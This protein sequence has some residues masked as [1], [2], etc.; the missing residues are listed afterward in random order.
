[1]IAIPRADDRGS[2][3]VGQVARGK[4]PAQPHSD[5]RNNL[6]ADANR[7]APSRP[8]DQWV[9]CR[10]PPLENGPMIYRKNLYTWEAALRVVAGLALIVYARVAMPGSL[11]GYG[12]AADGAVFALTG[13]FG[14][15][16]MCAMLGR[17]LKTP[18]ASA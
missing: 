12:L 1:M 2:L 11:L 5:F 4:G 18:G 3:Q 15:C 9:G 7:S 8:L 6:S 10:S 16:P 14:F 17:R 13:A